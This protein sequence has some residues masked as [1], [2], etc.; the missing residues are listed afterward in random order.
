MASECITLAVGALCI[1]VALSTKSYTGARIDRH[2]YP[3]GDFELTLT[4]RLM[5]PW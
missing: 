2:V 4:F 5:F 3:K 1:V